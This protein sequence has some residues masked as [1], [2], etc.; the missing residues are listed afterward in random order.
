MVMP[1]KTWGKLLWLYKKIYPRKRVRSRGRNP[2]KHPSSDSS[3][4][5]VDIEEQVDSSRDKLNWGVWS[6]LHI[7]EISEENK[8]LFCS[9]SYLV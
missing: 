7:Q 3:A 9:S 5:D 1:C 4:N 8:A 2:P 6:S